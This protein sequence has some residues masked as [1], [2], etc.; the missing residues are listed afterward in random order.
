MGNNLR[1]A[2]RRTG[3]SAAPTEIR[4]GRR[5]PGHLHCVAEYLYPRFCVHLHQ[6]VTGSLQFPPSL[7]AGG[8]E[9][10][11]IR[12][13]AKGSCGQSRHLVAGVASVVTLVLVPPVGHQLMGGFRMGR[14]G[15]DVCAHGAEDYLQLSG[16][17]R[18]CTGRSRIVCQR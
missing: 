17:H 10:F 5:C 1:Q 2:Q 4:R 3:Y 6:I 16:L 8:I 12:R 13:A 7:L 11:H 18:N 9:R 14:V 15:D